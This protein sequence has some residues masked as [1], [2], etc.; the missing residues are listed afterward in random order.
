MKIVKDYPPNIEEIKKYFKITPNTVFTYGDTLYS[1]QGIKLPDHLIEHE[2]VHQKQ[3][4]K[5]PAGW[6]NEYIKQS[7]FRLDQELEAYRKQFQFYKI[8]NKTW[9]PFLKKI[10]LDLSGPIYGN[11]ISYWEAFNLL[12]IKP[13]QKI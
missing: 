12:L 6:W 8:K 9:M 4:G 5:Q 11:I 3:Q 10:V 1:P 2:K 13:K 7:T